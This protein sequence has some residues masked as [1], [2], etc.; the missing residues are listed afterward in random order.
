MTNENKF[1]F[2]SRSMDS[3]LNNTISIQNPYGLDNSYDMISPNIPEVPQFDHV[4]HYSSS[5][6]QLDSRSIE[7]KFQIL[8]DQINHL[9]FDND[10]LREKVFEF[11]REQQQ[12]DDKLNDLTNKLEQLADIVLKNKDEI[13]VLSKRNLIVNFGN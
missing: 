7:K 10:S 8:K 11:E 3:N 6:Y 13:E 4:D 5:Q 12:K 9:R 2:R 1:S